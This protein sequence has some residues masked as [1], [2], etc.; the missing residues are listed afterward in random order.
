LSVSVNL[1]AFTDACERAF[2]NTYEANALNVRP[3]FGFCLHVLTIFVKGRKGMEWVIDNIK[4]E[5]DDIS[6]KISPTELYK[7][8]K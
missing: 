6:Q 3:I 8:L 1:P 5:F 4:Q 2:L 7:I